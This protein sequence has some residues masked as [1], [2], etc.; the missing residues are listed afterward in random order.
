M[1]WS[2]MS[3]VPNP[4]IVDA[5]GTAGSGY[6][7]KA[8]LPGTTTSTSIAIAA[9]GS[10][11][12]A[13]ITANA[14]GKWEVSGN[15]ILPFIDKTHKWGIFANVSDA[16][17]N[18]PFYMGPFDNIVPIAA[19]GTVSNQELTVSSMAANTGKYYVVGDV[20]TTAER[21]TGNGGGGTYDVVLT[22]SV[23]PNGFNIIIGVSDPLI[24]FVLR[25][26]VVEDPRRW[27]AV[28]D[29]ST[30]IGPTLN[31]M[32][33]LG[34]IPGIP[35]N[36]GVINTRVDI[37][38]NSKI[39]F[40]GSRLR[41]TVD[42]TIMFQANSSD[43]WAL[44][45]SVEIKGTLIVSGVSAETGLRIVGGRR[46]KVENITSR[47]FQG[48]G[49]DFDNDGTTGTRGQKGQLNNCAAYECTLGWDFNDGQSAEYQVLTGC[50]AS[51][52]VDG[53]QIQAGNINWT[54]G[55]ITDNGTGVTLVSGA[56]E[57]HGIMTGVNINHND[58]NLSAV[59]IILGFNF[60]GCNWY[61]SGAGTSRI[62]IE[63][64]R[65]IVI[66]GG[67]WD[68]PVEI[69]DGAATSNGLNMLRNMKVAGPVAGLSGDDLT[70]LRS[71]GHYDFFGQSPSLYLAAQPVLVIDG[72]VTGTHDGS[73]GAAVLTDSSAS[74]TT[75]QLIGRT[76]SNTT[77]G[78]TATITANTATTITG[79]LSGGT[80]DDWDAS[81]GYTIDAVGFINSWTNSGGGMSAGYWVT[82]SG[83]LALQGEVSTGTVGQNMFS[84]PFTFDAAIEILV[85]AN[86]VSAPLFI[87]TAGN[88]QLLSGSNT[89]VSLD[90][91]RLRIKT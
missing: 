77:D 83:D 27:G 32:L 43:D 14:E 63:N 84:V 59:D 33:A 30:D 11:P 62:I 18:T 23:T 76:I 72:Q 79:T 8:Y 50:N 15:E 60:F 39:V 1:P 41:T 61:S 58:I 12:Q 40:Y 55:N 16:A 56:N 89:K 69:E 47:L 80:N 46:Y 64:S 34:I 67:D 38:D 54:G 19:P 3:D 53:V 65:G 91:I 66:D 20:V 68:C 85:S 21:S 42:T 13:L 74:W 22:S 88:I 4:I 78:S 71:Y 25:Q 57:A 49:F 5:A 37:L 44:L 90:G 75:N 87:D 31:A 7:L 70:N 9:D 35:N 51:G 73:S 48:K 45:G 36:L 28:F 24:S 82:E 86:G 29:D 2:V 81:D 17:A 10:S 26:K 52:C 6:I